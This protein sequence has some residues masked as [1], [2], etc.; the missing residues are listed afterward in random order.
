MY[1]LDYDDSVPVHHVTSLNASGPDDPASTA[2]LH[3]LLLNAMVHILADK[4]NV[5]DLAE[6]AVQKFKKHF[7]EQSSAD[8]S[9]FTDVI[10]YVYS[11]TPEHH[12]GLRDYIRRFSAENSQKLLDD[13]GSSPLTDALSTTPI[14]AQELCLELVRLRRAIGKYKCSNQSCQYVCHIENLDRDKIYYCMSCS[15]GC[16]ADTWEARKVKD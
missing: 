3:P 5:P 13:N 12:R 14:F 10:H 6:L 7:P 9:V 16:W 4:Y 8:D 15:N 1:T 2:Q 11:N